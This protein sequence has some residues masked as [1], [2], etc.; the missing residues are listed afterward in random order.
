MLKD[1]NVE[2]SEAAKVVVDYEVNRY[3]A[4]LAL[5]NG[6]YIQ[7][8][9]AYF[10]NGVRENTEFQKYVNEWKLPLVCSRMVCAKRNKEFFGA[11]VF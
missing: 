6:S 5:N 3:V 9:A 7:F 2:Q 4:Y 1:L 10:W 11:T 8:H